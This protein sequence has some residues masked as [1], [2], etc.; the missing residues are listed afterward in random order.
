MR[1]TEFIVEGLAE[2]LTPPNEFL[3]KAEKL[4]A[5]DKVFY[6]GKLVGIATGEINDDKVI[7]K[8]IA[9]YGNRE[10]F[11]SLPIDQISLR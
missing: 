7:F 6:K 2:G 5:G 4:K 9:S 3:S 10:N 11:A 1:A 8:P